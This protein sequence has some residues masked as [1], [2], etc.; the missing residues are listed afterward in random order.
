MAGDDQRHRV[1]A[2]RA[3]H[4]AH[5]GRVADGARDLGVSARLAPRDAAQRAPHAALEHRAADV[6]RDPGEIAFSRQKGSD[7]VANLSQRRGILDQLRRAEFLADQAP[8]LRL[9]VAELDGA[10]AA[11]GRRDQGPADRQ[12]EDGIADSLAAAAGA[13]AARRHAEAGGRLFVEARGRAVAGVEQRRGD[14]AAILERGLDR[15]QAMRV[16]VVAR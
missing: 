10:E 6:H 9:V 8:Q 16:L 13:V 15:F 5:G 14:P 12:R 2:A 4:R 3:A 1:G 11:R 7:A